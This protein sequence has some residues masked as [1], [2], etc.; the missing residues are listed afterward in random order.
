MIKLEQVGDNAPRDVKFTV[1]PS[2]VER[3]INYIREA[4][5]ETDD[6]LSAFSEPL[7][8]HEDTDDGHVTF[9]VEGGLVGE[10]VEIV[11][12]PHLEDEL[13]RLNQAAIDAAT[14]D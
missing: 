1:D 5:D 12:D 11:Q 14:A 8:N 10:L 9:T 7:E 3:W 2:D 4:E 6:D 13:E